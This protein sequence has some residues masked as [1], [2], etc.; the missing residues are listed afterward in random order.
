MKDQNIFIPLHNL[1]NQ[2]DENFLTEIFVYL[3]NHYLKYEKQAALLLIKRMTDNKIK[4]VETELI[5]LDISTRAKT[6]EGVPDIY[7]FSKNVLIFIEV[8]V[9]SD[10]GWKQLSKYKEVLEKSEKITMLITLTRYHHKLHNPDIEPDYGFRWHHLS[11]WLNELDLN[12]EI[13]RFLTNQYIELLKH[14]GVAM[15]KTNWQLVEGVKSLKNLVDMIGEALS[16]AS[17]QIHSK[18]G[19]WKWMGYY[20]EEKKF[21]VGIYYDTPNFIFLNTEVALLDGIPKEPEIG[22]YDGGGWQN[23]LDME[24]ESEYFFSRTKAS[25]IILLEKFLKKNVDYGKTLVAS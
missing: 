7:V 16:S 5:G 10:F 8:K 17:I 20:I 18:S 3:L 13:S 22:E 14:R 6:E 25:Q 4:I 19:A 12:L 21:F 15:E 2:Q 9:D 23:G 11:D 1:A 24:S